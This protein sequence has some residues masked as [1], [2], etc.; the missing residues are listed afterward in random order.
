MLHPAL[1]AIPVTPSGSAIFPAPRGLFSI[2]L[3]PMRRRRITL[4]STSSNCS[5]SAPPGAAIESLAIPFDC[6]PLRTATRWAPGGPTV[7]FHIGLE[8]VDDLIADLEGG[9]AALTRRL[10]V[11]RS[12]G[13][14]R[15]PAVAHDKIKIAQIDEN[16]GALAGD[17]H[18]VL[19][20]ERIDQQ[21]DTAEDR[22]YPERRGTT[23][24]PARS[25]SDP[26]HHE[27]HGEQ[28]LGDKADD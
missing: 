14:Q 7:R 28:P 25:R 5:V 10:R 19:A 15:R 11:M 22:E 26:L 27:T 13:R 1:R 8:A 20:V 24:W 6:A 2:V 4:L 9:F 21:Q 16:P 18:R 17:E 23:L 12:R 3:K